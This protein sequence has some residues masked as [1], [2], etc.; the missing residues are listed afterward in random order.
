LRPII[1][2]IIGAIGKP[3]PKLNPRLEPKPEPKPNPRP[4][5]RPDPDHG[6]E[7]D[8]DRTPICHDEPVYRTVAYSCMKAISVPYEVFDHNSKANVVVK[9][10]AAP[11]KKPQSGNCGIKFNLG[12][13]ALA[14]TNTCD[15]YL[16]VY[17]KTV[18]GHGD[19]KN[20]N[21][22]VKLYN[23]ETVLAPLAGGLQDMHMDGDDLVVQTGNLVGATNFKLKLY[24]QRRR[25][26]QS[27]VVLIDRELN[28]EEFSYEAVDER[29]GL[30]H[31]NLGKVIDG[32][33]ASRK[34][35]IKLSLDVNIEAGTL[36][37]GGNLPDLHQ[38][39]SITI[40]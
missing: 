15:D 35:V 36:M 22:S 12:G 18:E 14:V 25:L 11:S 31:I 20:Y 9:V 13:A 1:K 17:N 38:E 21:Y 2:P 37:N 7:H 4:D 39:A 5:P 19:E 8:H 30:V 40:H 16:A 3:D 29:T 10:A 27:D 34:N 6:H 33:E 28:S 26:V 32:F 24:V 23:A